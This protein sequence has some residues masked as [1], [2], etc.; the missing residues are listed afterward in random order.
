MRTVAFLKNFG[1]D[2]VELE[3]PGKLA[4]EDLE[5][6][7]NIRPLAG[8]DGFLSEYAMVRDNRAKLAL[9]DHR[10]AQLFDPDRKV[11][12]IVRRVVHVEG[13]LSV[14]E[15]LREKGERLE[16]KPIAKGHQPPVFDRL[17]ASKEEALKEIAKHLA[18]PQELLQAEGIVDGVPV[19]LGTPWRSPV[20]FRPPAAVIN[21]GVGAQSADG[22]LQL[23]INQIGGH[24]SARII[25]QDDSLRSRGGRVVLAAGDGV[26]ICS[27]GCPELCAQEHRFQVYLRGQDRQNDGHHMEYDF[28]TQEQATCIRNEIV[29]LVSAMNGKS[30]GEALLAGGSEWTVSSKGS[31]LRVKLA[32][33]DCRLEAQV[34]E[35]E[36][37]LRDTMMIKAGHGWEVISNSHPELQK[38]ADHN[39]FFIRGHDRECDSRVAQLNYPTR[40]AAEAARTALAALITEI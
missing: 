5:V 37:S 7:L 27:Y 18:T 4:G 38:G 30:A 3:V 13:A 29:R 17:Q 39:H 23:Q 21:M 33:K 6:T 1:S 15:H 36:E 28:D 25:A 11:I 12:A 34:L 35:Q 10:I 2:W 20:G 22:K 14:P 31:R 24:L 8:Q 40:Q 32:V 9:P 26:D 19:K 16:I